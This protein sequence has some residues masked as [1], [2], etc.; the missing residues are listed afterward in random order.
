M[1]QEYQ[2]WKTLSLALVLFLLMEFLLQLRAQLKFGNSILTSAFASDNAAVALFE[3]HNGY[4]LLTPDIEFEGS[5]IKVQSNHLGLRSAAINAKAQNT[6][7]VIALGASSTYGAYAASNDATFP[8]L[9]Q[10]LS[11]TIPLEVINAGIPG[12][13][14]SSQYRL[15]AEHLTGMSEDVLLL[16]TGLSN[17]VGRICRANSSKLSYALPQLQAP[18]WLL[19]VDLLLKNSTNLRYVPYKYAA[20]PDLSVYLQQYAEALRRI[21]LL[22]QQRGVKAVL[23]AENLRAF[24]PEQSEALQQQL[25]AS[26]LYYT[27]CLSVQ[28]FSAVF[29]QYN[30]VQQQVAAEFALAHYLPLSAQVP[31]GREHFTD[32]V[33][34]SAKGEQ[35]MALALAQAINTRLR[36][37]P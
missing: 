14:I 17:D 21:V 2:T 4:Q 24:R 11:Q 15:Y 29:E 19:T 9:L 6:T 7:R 22:A 32:S 28:Q 35:A 18:K 27:P 34:F 23:L 10:R 36:E 13:D 37:A 1:T 33:H 30:L 3:Q 8:A 31:G 26:A 25:A 12:N 20:M 5:S 16:Y